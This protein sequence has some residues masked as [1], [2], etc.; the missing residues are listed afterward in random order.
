MGGAWNPTDQHIAPAMGLLAHA[1]ELDR[2]SRRGDGLVLGRISYDIFGTVPVEV[3]ETEVRVLRPGRTIE[4]VEAVLGHAGRR[5]MAARVWL[6]QRY[7]TAELAGTPLAGIPPPERMTPWDPSTVWPGDFLGSLEVRREQA[8]PGRAAFWIRPRQALVEAEP[9]SPTARAAGLLDLA[10]GM[11]VRVSPQEVAFPNIDLTV[12]FL[13]EPDDGW[14]GFDTS[15][16]FGSGG[17]GVTSSVIYGTS[18]PVGTMSQ[19]LTLRP[20]GGR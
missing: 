2:D 10:N 11:T 1:V 16:S 12:H 7:P 18:G 17:V 19:I 9:V 20:L 3:V 14:L 15:V 5:I 6:M 4:L 13:E 8:G